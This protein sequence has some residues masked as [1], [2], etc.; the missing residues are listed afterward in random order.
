MGVYC[1]LNVTS[2]TVKQF[3]I[4]A[5]MDVNLDSIVFLFI[6]INAL[7]LSASTVSA[8]NLL[9]ARVYARHGRELMGLKSPVLEPVCLPTKIRKVLAKGNR[10]RATDHGKE[11]G[12]QNCEPTNRNSI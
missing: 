10:G 4:I 8:A 9:R 6:L 5:M 7:I 12:E 3:C 11:A 1:S 2:H